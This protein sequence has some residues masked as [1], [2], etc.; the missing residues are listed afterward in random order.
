MQ[1]TNQKITSINMT[2]A[3]NWF[4]YGLASIFSLAHSP[5]LLYL[6]FCIFASIKCMTC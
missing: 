3:Q 1:T 4:T 2:F 5:I 6:Y